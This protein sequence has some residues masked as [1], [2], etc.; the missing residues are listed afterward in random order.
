MPELANGYNVRVDYPNLGGV[1]VEQ[2]VLGPGQT[3]TVVPVRGEP[4]LDGTAAL[5]DH[6][7]A[8][9]PHVNAESGRDF[10]AWYS[11]AIVGG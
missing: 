8:P 6:V 10:A 7:A 11:A 1:R 2:P 5:I 9:R 3:V 4:G